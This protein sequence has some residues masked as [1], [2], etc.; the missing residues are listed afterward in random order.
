M[1]KRLGADDA[2]R[3]ATR[4]R[5]SLAGT[6]PFELRV[7]GVDVFE[8][9]AAG[10]SPVVYLRVASPELDRLHDRLCEVFAPVDGME[11][12]AYVPHVT[13]AR[14]GDPATARRLADRSVEPRRW[15]AEE[16]CVWDG[17]RRLPVRT[18]SLPM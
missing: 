13:I 1:C 5:D 14:G 16:L 15:T 7:S 18:F 8:E 6:A 9:A 2:A 4:V 17:T 11:G 3:L 12:D 10:E